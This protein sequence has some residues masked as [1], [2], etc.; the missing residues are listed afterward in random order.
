MMEILIQNNITG[1]VFN[2]SE[3]IGSI[4]YGT[5]RIGKASDLKITFLKDKSIDIKHGNIILFRKDDTSLFYGYVFKIEYNEKKV[6]SVTCY[7]QMRYLLN[8]DTYVFKNKR[9]DEILNRIASDFNLKIGIVENTG[10]T[11]P[12]MVEDGQTLLDIIYKALDWTLV[13]TGEM[14]I[15]YD[16][17]GKLN[18]KNIKNME[19]DIKLGDKNLVTSYRYST[20]ID[21]DT[22]NKIKLVKDNKKTG[23]R[24]VYIIK[25]SNN[26]KSWGVL[27][28]YEKVNEKLN[29]AQIVERANNLEKVKNRIKRDLKVNAIGDIRIRAGNTVYIDITE[30]GLKQKYI[31]DSASHSFKGS[32]HDMSLTLRI[33]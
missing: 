30:I 8:K 10:Y 32:I 15:L 21:K 7:D 9:A 1:K 29:E 31:V 6:L 16:D 25:D 23:K 14:F 26:I 20:D 22:F 11:I 5:A 19:L 27:Q 12:S 24:D 17:F 33:I 28:Y 2:I 4:S 3:L 13:N 18:L